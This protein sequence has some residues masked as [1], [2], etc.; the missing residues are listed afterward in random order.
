MLIV[1]WGDVV[2]V[3]LQVTNRYAMQRRQPCAN[4]SRKGERRL[5]NVLILRVTWTLLQVTKMLLVQ[6]L[7]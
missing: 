1:L 4:S 7:C 6:H 2:V 5:K 3:A